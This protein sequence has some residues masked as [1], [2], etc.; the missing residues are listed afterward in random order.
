MLTRTY[1]KFTQVDYLSHWPGNF[2][3][4]KKTN[5]TGTNLR[6]V[7]SR[8]VFLLPVY[9]LPGL[10]YTW[11][12]Q[13]PFSTRRLIG[14][15]QTLISPSILTII[16][17]LLFFD[18][19]AMCWC[20]KK[21]HWQ[22]HADSLWLSFLSLPLLCRLRSHQSLSATT[23]GR[24][25]EKMAHTTRRGAFLL[26]LRPWRWI[27]GKNECNSLVDSKTRNEDF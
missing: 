16:G 7:Q 5:S 6:R 20:L 15:A 21:T 18:K 9:A 2:H 17:R 23:T 3:P 19:L 11:G 10:S 4:Q 8:C 26:L 13:C 24:R 1:E 12:T 14:P 27:K 22:L 25:R